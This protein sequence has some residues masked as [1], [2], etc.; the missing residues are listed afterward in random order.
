MQRMMYVDPHDVLS[1]SDE[2]LEGEMDPCSARGWHSLSMLCEGLCS[3]AIGTNVRSDDEYAY[4]A[5]P[6]RVSPSCSRTSPCTAVLTDASKRGFRT[7][8]RSSQ[9]THPAS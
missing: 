7:R 1:C 9:M 5:K 4:A 2:T 3:S 8:H 6:G